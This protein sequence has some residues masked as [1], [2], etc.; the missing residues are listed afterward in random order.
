MHRA[1]RK[2]FGALILSVLLEEEL[3][4]PYCFPP[5]FT[6]HYSRGMTNVELLEL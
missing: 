3:A 1:K 2:A 6:K 4:L 5:E